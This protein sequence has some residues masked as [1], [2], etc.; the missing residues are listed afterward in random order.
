MSQNH[1]DPMLPHG[2]DKCR[3]PACGLYFNSTFAF[4]SHRIGR[5]TSGRRC[6]S[7]DELLAMGWSQ[8]QTGHWITEA[9]SEGAA[10][11]LARH[12]TN[13]LLDEVLP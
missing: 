1:R 7:G 10:I 13:S 12:G 9:N 3:C 2:T 5:V 11:R 8:S 6:R 4:D